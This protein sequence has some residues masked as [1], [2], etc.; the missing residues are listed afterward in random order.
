MQRKGNQPS[1][2]VGENINWYTHMENT[3]EVPQKTKTRVA[4]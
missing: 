2:T 3:I 4:I 1:H